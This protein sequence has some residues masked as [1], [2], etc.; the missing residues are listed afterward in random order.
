M[1]NMLHHFRWSP[2]MWRR[3]LKRSSPASAGRPPRVAS[4]VEAWIETNRIV[5]EWGKDIVAS[6]VEAW[7]ETVT[8]RLRPLGVIVAS[9]V[10]AWIETSSISTAA[11][12]ILSPPMWRRGLKHRSWTMALIHVRVASH[13]EAWIETL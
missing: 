10:E 2:P 5:A 3:G 13:V 8:I 7:I 1:S 6:H 12:S 11:V 4:H 9:H